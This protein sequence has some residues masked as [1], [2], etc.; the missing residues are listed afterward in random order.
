MAKRDEK[1]KTVVVDGK[2]FELTPKGNL[3]EM[4]KAKADET[5]ER[6]GRAAFDA[7]R[8]YEFP[9]PELSEKKGAAELR[10][11]RDAS[12]SG[13]APSHLIKAF[14]RSMYEARRGKMMSPAG[15][16]EEFKKEEHFENG[17]WRKFYVNRLR[18]AS[19]SAADAFRAD[20]IMRACTIAAGFT[21]THRAD[22]VSY[23]KPHRAK[24][25]IAK[26]LPGVREV[27]CPFN[28]FSGIALGAAV[29]NGARYIGQ[30]LNA[31]EVSESVALLAFAEGKGFLSPGQAVVSV[32]DVFQDSGEYEALVA[33]PPY[34]D[35]K[36][37]NIEKWNFGPNGE[38]LD[39]SLP[40]DDWI[41]E[42]L[43]RYRCGSYL[44]VVDEKTTVRHRKNVVETFSNRCHFG[45]NT[46]FVVL[47][48]K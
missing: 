15:F 37:G 17:D 9:Y 45:D 44:F 2:E 11:L 25:L 26:Y 3:F 42:C 18:N 43:S 5:Y 14:H 40:C 47:I 23:F 30:D 36:T 22:T 31:K 21:I 19:T 13:S 48:R 6:M 28:G 39:V 41:D 34:G 46:E 35:P 10:N 20:G 27:F 7:Y 32:K 16:W 1:L 24:N 12:K 38:E 4:T 29:G 33:C 8:G